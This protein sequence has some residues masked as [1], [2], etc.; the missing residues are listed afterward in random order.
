MK[1]K[2][3]LNT[4]VHVPLR[5]VGFM[6]GTNTLQWHKTQQK[7]EIMYIKGSILKKRFKSEDIY[8]LMIHTVDI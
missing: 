6:P 1:T 4:H 5:Y 7:I 8:H 2:K 3:V